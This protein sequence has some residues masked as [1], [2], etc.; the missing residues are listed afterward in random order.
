M[1]NAARVASQVMY[2]AQTR[3]APTRPRTLGFRPYS[4]FLGEAATRD[5]QGLSDSGV[6]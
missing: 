1:C 3:C 4:A 5:S 2:A 6:I